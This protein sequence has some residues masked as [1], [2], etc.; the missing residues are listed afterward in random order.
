[1]TSHPISRSTRSSAQTT[2]SMAAQNRFTCAA[3]GT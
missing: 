3:N 1:M 2:S